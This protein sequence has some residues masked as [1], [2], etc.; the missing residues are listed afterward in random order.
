MLR[1]ALVLGCILGGSGCLYLVGDD[2]HDSDELPPGPPPPPIVCGDRERQGGEA[3]DDGNLIDGDGCS[4]TCRIDA[5][6]HV[7]WR[8]ATL[9]GEPRPCP[10]GFDVAEV[11]TQ[12]GTFSVKHMARFDCAA[13][14]GAVIVEQHSPEIGHDVQVLIKSSAT[15]E[16]Y[17][18]SEIDH[19]D[20]QR[21]TSTSH[22]IPTDA[23]KIRTH[24]T[25][26]VGQTPTFCAGVASVD[27]V[28]R[29]TAGALFS[30]TFPCGQNVGLTPL[31]PAGSYRV[32]VTAQRAGQSRTAALDGVAVPTGGRAVLT[33]SA[34]LVF[35][36]TL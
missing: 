20:L 9:A 10:D 28:V 13:G 30:G 15:G 29:S 27:V 22:A 25:I 23:G 33:D 6:L 4:S 17:G 12:E 34:D 1:L 35:S 2:I 14:E 8:L 5:T 31:L 18:E 21:R 32:E 26:W 16:L 36:G 11:V 7:S 19:V 24:W 3:C